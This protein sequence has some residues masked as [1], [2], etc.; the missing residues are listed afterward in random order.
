MLKLPSD[1]RDAVGRRI[2][3]LTPAELAAFADQRWHSRNNVTPQSSGVPVAALLDLSLDETAGSVAAVASQGKTCRGG[4]SK[5][6]GPAPKGDKVP[7]KPKD[8]SSWMCLPHAKY[9]DK[10]YSCGDPKNCRHSG[11]GG[12][13]SH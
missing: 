9:G 5:H 4:R 8:V 6:G 2:A 13:G 7:E 11:N 3:D 10:A 12:A 1:L